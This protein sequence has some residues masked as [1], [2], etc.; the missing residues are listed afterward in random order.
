VGAAA[1]G[2]RVALANMGS[3]PLRATATERALASG[4]SVADAAALAA[5]GT[6][7]GADLHADVEYRQ[8]LARVL[9][10]RALGAAAA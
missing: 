10:A 2:G 3:R 4:A 8:H 9:T 1:I 6:E 7:P 5:E